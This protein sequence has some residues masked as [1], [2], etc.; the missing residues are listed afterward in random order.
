MKPLDIKVRIERSIQHVA[1]PLPAPCW[2]CSIRKNRHGYP[3]FRVGRKFRLAHRLSFEAYN[4]PLVPGMEICHACDNPKCINPAHLW[5]GTHKENFADA[6]SKGRIA[7]GDRHWKRRCPEKVLRAQDHPQS[8][9]NE[10]QRR[11]IRATHRMDAARGSMKII[12]DA[13]GISR[14]LYI[15][16]RES[17]PDALYA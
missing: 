3:L 12:V 1:G 4:G 16:V 6:V 13:W 10:W 5:Q 17:T 11:I 8:K 9:L 15:K 14:A 7:C 2:I